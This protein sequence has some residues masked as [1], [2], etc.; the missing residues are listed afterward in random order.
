MDLSENIEQILSDGVSGNIPPDEFLRRVWKAV[1]ADPF[2]P[3]G[4]PVAIHGWTSRGREIR[5]LVQAARDRKTD[6]DVAGV[7]KVLARIFTTDRITGER[8]PEFEKAKALGWPA[9]QDRGEIRATE[10]DW[11]LRGTRT[12][13]GSG[14]PLFDSE[15]VVMA[16]HAVEV[17]TEIREHIAL[18]GVEAV[19][20]IIDAM[21][22]EREALIPDP[23]EEDGEE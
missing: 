22:A 11:P 1:E 23:I 20:D 6:Q 5:E 8:S 16:R 17:L 15:E 19:S 4:I 18:Q 2:D 13:W 9:T 12:P 7:I 21:I 14:N 3:A 10:P